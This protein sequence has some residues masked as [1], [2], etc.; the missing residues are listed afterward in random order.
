MIWDG[1]SNRGYTVLL[2]SILILA[3]FSWWIGH[4]HNNVNGWINLNKSYL[5]GIERSVVGEWI[6]FYLLLVDVEFRNRDIFK[7]FY[8]FLRKALGPNAYPLIEGRAV[9]LVYDFLTYSAFIGIYVPPVLSRVSLRRVYPSCIG[10]SRFRLLLRRRNWLQFERWLSMR[11][12]GKN[13][14]WFGLYPC[15]FRLY[16]FLGLIKELGSDY[17]LERILRAIARL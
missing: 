4:N 7:V 16:L 17:H 3:L 2:F 1:D 10:D 8:I 5:K 13:I 11:K 9:I 14:L 6:L 15:F 12:Q